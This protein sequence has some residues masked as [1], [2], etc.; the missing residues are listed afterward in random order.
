MHYSTPFIQ[1]TFAINAT[2]GIPQFSLIVQGDILDTL[3]KQ[4][5]T[6][7]IFEQVLAAGGTTKIPKNLLTSLS[8]GD[9]MSY[10]GG[11]VVAV[12]ILQS[13]CP[14]APWIGAWTS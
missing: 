5:Q 1:S 7:V 9:L 4:D 14:Q 13:R 11:A 3:L 2:T 10:S 12:A 6:V 8:V